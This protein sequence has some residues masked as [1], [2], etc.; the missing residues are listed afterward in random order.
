MD[1]CWWLLALALVGCSSSDESNGN[2]SGGFPAGTTCGVS[3]A[4]SGGVDESLSASD[5]V[6]CATQLSSSTGIDADFLPLDSG[7]LDAV[8][9][10]IDDV[11]KG[12]TGGAFPTEVRV[13]GA[14]NG[15]W[16]ATCTA[17]ISTNAFDDTDDFADHYRTTGTG[18]CTGTATSSTGEPDVAIGPLSFVVVV[19]WTK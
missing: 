4:L 9:I 18:T 10:R 7:S 19:P 17:D 16:T 3:V 8:S 5:S 2:G 13:H 6:A 15:L 11:E 12:E 1:D 14:D